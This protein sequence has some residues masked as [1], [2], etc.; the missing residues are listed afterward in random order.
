LNGPDKYFGL[1]AEQAKDDFYARVDGILAGADPRFTPAGGGTL[2]L[3]NPT[4]DTM[5]DDGR[6]ELIAIADGYRESE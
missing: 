1:S 5:I 2:D 6:K 4:L 3:L